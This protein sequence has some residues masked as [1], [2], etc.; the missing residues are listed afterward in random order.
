MNLAKPL[1][2]LGLSLAALPQ[3][4]ACYTVYDSSNRVVYSAQEPPVDMQFQIHQV[5]PRVFPNAHMVFGDEPD[6]PLVDARR[7]AFTVTAAAPAPQRYRVV[8]VVAQ[9]GD[10]APKADRN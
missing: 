1:L 3:A 5:L 9:R 2:V 4:M 7:K 8:A 10:L 6:C